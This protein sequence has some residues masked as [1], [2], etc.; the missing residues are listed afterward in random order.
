MATF[1]AEWRQGIDTCRHCVYNKIEVLKHEDKKRRY[2][3]TTNT[4][5]CK[6]E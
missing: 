1:S 2:T 4:N 5:S 6:S 3:R